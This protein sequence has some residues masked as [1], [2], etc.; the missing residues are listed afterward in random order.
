[1]DGDLSE[2]SM[3]NVALYDNSSSATN[4]SGGV[5]GGGGG[6]GHNSI[7]SM[8][9]SNPSQTSSSGM[10]STNMQV[11]GPVRP[12]SLPQYNANAP[13]SSF[14]APNSVNSPGSK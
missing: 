9:S 3:Q 13:A 8:M 6:G 4:G 2:G 12:N 7:P 11:G 5:G 14:S 10:S 1:M